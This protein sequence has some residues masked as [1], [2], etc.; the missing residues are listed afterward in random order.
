MNHD[1]KKLLVWLQATP[2][3]LAPWGDWA[4][5]SEWNLIRRQ[6]YGKTTRFGWV[7]DHIVPKSMGGSD[8]LRNLQPLQWY[9]NQVKSNRM[10]L[11][12][13]RV[14]LGVE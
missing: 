10:P 12:H 6:D 5:D 2:A 9:A 11:E 1:I 13:L 8:D 7:I 4:W 14:I 3:P